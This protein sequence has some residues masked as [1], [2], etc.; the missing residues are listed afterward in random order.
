MLSPESIV[1]VAAL[2]MT[3]GGGLI[4]LAFHAGRLSVRV[5]KLEQWQGHV[6]R[7]YFE[8]RTSDRV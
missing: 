5:D 8:M 2:L 1:A 3:L 4:T 7:K 6:Q